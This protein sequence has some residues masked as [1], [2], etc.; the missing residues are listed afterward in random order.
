MSKN[1]ICVLSAM[2][3]FLGII[4]GFLCA[5]IK[6][7]VYCGNHNGNTYLSPADELD[8]DEDEDVDSSDDLP[9]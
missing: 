6:K 4:I 2:F 3:L 9:F 1:F 8:L 5:P 7:G